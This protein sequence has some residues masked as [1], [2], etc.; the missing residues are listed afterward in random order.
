LLT[1]HPSTEQGTR[2]AF[3]V[4]L[5]NHGADAIPLTPC[6]VYRVQFNKVVE[7]GTLNCAAAPSSLPAHGHID[8][9]MQVWVQ[10]RG[11]AILP[12]EEELLWQLG[13]EGYE[14][15]LARADIRMVRS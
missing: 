1:D 15:R 3:V 7:A 10:R 14:G 13:G 9:D 2:F 8:F 6:P 4:R 12:Q 11:I 5:L